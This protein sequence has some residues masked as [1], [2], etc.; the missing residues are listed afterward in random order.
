MPIFVPAKTCI[1]L[2]V[3]ASFKFDSYN[4]GHGVETAV[5]DG[6]NTAQRSL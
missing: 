4:M 1:F 3:N 5:Y 2:K 6:V